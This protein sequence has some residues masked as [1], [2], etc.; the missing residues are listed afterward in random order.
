MATKIIRIEESPFELDFTLIG[1]TGLVKDYY[2]CVQLHKLLG[3]QFMAEA[4]LEKKTKAA[5]FR[6]E[7]FR[8][9][10]NNEH[11][12]IILFQ[13]RVEG[14]AMITELKQFDFL[15]KISGEWNAA[16][17]L[18]LI[19]LLKE[20]EKVNS[21]NKIDL[22]KLKQPDWLEFELPNKE[23]LERKK[24]VDRIKQFATPNL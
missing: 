6:Y 22:Q 7:L 19:A 12:E 8:A 11:T 5:V 4:A 21:V 1:I 20:L 18:K 2:I 24:Y 14:V 3:W 23:Y 10:I 13:N 15:I 17:E 9:F 16:T